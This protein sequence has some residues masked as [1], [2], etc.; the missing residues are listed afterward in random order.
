MSNK[1]SV[2]VPCYNQVLYL[3]ETLQSVFEQTHTNWECIIIDDGST[4]DSKVIAL[5]WCSVDSRFSYF[6][7]SNDGLSSARTS[8]S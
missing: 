3:D 5:K 1:V 6:Y 8:N 7:K 2:I 4:D